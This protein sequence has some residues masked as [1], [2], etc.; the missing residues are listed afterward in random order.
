MYI[1][2][3]TYIYMFTCIHTYINVSGVGCSTPHAENQSSVKRA[4]PA[5]ASAPP[6]TC[7]GMSHQNRAM[8]RDL[9]ILHIYIY[10]YIYIYVYMYACIYFFLYI[11]K[12]R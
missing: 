12:D 7:C 10:I 4:A 8:R 5:S 3:Y 2:V 1:H 11:Y 9:H 6:C